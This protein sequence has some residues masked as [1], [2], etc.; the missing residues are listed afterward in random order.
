M[1][2]RHCPPHTSFL[3]ATR[4]PPH[5]ADERYIRRL[6]KTGRD[7]IYVTPNDWTSLA[8]SGDLGTPALWVSP[9]Y[10]TFWFPAKIVVLF[11]TGRRS[12]LRVSY[13]SLPHWIHQTTDKLFLV[14]SA[15][16]LAKLD[17]FSLPNP[18]AVLTVDSEQTHIT[19][20]IEKS[21]NPYWNEH[22][23]VSVGLFSDPSCPWF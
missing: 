11:R 17:D 12:E 13:L 2:A 18:Y 1:G 8:M 6:V 3:V 19:G 10:P 7:W 5:V 14:V 9:W 15:D 22:F 20:V 21:R 16:G 4:T 23:D